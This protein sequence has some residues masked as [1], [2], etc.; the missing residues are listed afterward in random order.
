MIEWI[1]GN[2]EWIF[3]GIGIFILAGLFRVLTSK[4]NRSKG[5]QETASNSLREREVSSVIITD[6]ATING[7]VA[8]RDV[9]I[10]HTVPDIC[11]DE[12]VSIL[13]LRAAKIQGHLAEHYHYA[14]VKKYLS[15]FTKLHLQHIAALE[16]SNLVLAHEILTSIY[17]LS[18][19]LETDDFWKRHDCETPDLIYSLSPEMFQKGVLICEYVAGDMSSNSV[20]Y[21]RAIRLRSSKNLKTI[22]EIY[23]QILKTHNLQRNNQS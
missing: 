19:G 9:V 20:L 17:E 3:S 1:S 10:N 15:K 23:K 11:T 22:N 8:G 16:K 5:P 13:Q 14:S 18:N 6:N 12:L 21:P 7:T 4:K 2:Y